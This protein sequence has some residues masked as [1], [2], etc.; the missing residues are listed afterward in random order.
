MSYYSLTGIAEH[1][2][3]RYDVETAIA[4]ICGHDVTELSKNY[5]R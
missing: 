1:L 2:F 5:K 4:I 3:S